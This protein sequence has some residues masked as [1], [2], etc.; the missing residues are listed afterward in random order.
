[1]GEIKERV[2]VRPSTEREGGQGNG[3]RT[4]VFGGGLGEIKECIQVRPSPPLNARVVRV[5]GL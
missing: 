5:T 3:L 1:M 4:E 2:Q